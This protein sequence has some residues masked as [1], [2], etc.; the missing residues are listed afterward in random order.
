M[1]KTFLALSAISVLMLSGCGKDA[2]PAPTQEP[3][4]AGA[5]DVAAAAADASMSPVVLSDYRMADGAPSAGHCALDALNGQR[6]PSITLPA[7]SQATMGGWV[8]DAGLQAPAAALMV[9][10][11]SESTLAAPLGTGASRPD[12]AAALGSEALAFAGFNVAVDLAEVPAG[13][14]QLL[15]VVDQGT[16]AYCD[17]NTTLV[18]E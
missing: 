7:A 8:A 4:A 12:V 14:Y 2:P 16:S 11:G 1:N 15:A 10:R 9:L 3:A 5:A 13:S 18:I 6:G 17:F